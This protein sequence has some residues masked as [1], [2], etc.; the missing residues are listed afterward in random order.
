MATY[1][2]IWFAQPKCWGIIEY[3]NGMSFDETQELL[4]YHQGLVDADR[5]IKEQ[6]ALEA[7][8]AKKVKKV[9]KRIKPKKKKNKEIEILKF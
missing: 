4:T 6:Q 5:K 1:T 9:V 3:K 2:I 7:Q 8:E